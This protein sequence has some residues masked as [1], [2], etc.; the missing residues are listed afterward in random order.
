M[1]LLAVACLCLS[2]AEIIGAY[3]IRQNEKSINMTAEHITKTLAL[4]I[5]QGR[6]LEKTQKELHMLKLDVE[7]L[8]TK[9]EIERT[10]KDD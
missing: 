3:R 2:V 6:D 5:E 1:K 8:P 10:L 4:M 7:Y 9:I